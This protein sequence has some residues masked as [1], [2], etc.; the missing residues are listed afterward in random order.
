MTAVWP[1]PKSEMQSL[2]LR[3][4]TAQLLTKAHPAQKF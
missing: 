2:A 3:E 4:I 1:D